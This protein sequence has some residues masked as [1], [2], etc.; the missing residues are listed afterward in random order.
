MNIAGFDHYHNKLRKSADLTLFK[1]CSSKYRAI[2]G[3][4]LKARANLK[5][6]LFLKQCELVI[7]KLGIGVN[8]ALSGFVNCCQRNSYLGKINI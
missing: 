8:Y 2:K 1:L 7:K 3:L 6:K 5:K 4:N